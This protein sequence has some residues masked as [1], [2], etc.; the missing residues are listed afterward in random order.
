MIKT[1]YLDLE[2]TGLDPVKNS[3]IQ[4]AAIVEYDGEEVD[5]V[6]IKMQPFD[7][8][9]VEEEALA[10]I[11]ITIDDMMGW[12]G[13]HEGFELVKEFLNRHIDPYDKNDKF[14]VAGFNIRFDLDFLQRFFRYNGDK[15]GI[16]TYFNWKYIDV[17]A[18]VNLMA[19]KGKINLPNHK[20][21]TVC[22]HFG[23][24]L[25]NAHDAMDDTEASRD[26]IRKLLS[27]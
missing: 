3:V 6:D 13:H 8:A 25:E 15:Y 14:W 20:L 5:R 9:E 24:I 7:D 10:K 11:G 21:I 18:L 4:F 26:L 19:W 22:E 2:T 12:V 23:I 16:G 1:L 27:K 17:M